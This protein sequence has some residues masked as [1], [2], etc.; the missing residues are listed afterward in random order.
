MSMKQ[1]T[2]YQMNKYLSSLA[3]P[4]RKECHSDVTK[5]YNGI[6]LVAEVH[7]QVN[8]PST[9]WIVEQ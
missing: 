5:F 6:I 9:Y 4:F 8:K 7:H 2:Q 1:V 3:F